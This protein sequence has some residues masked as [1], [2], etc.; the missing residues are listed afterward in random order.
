M[1]DD[2]SVLEQD[3]LA[4]AL[5]VADTVENGEERS[6][7]MEA[8]A[9]DYAQRRDLSRAVELVE[10]ISDPY[11]KD[12]ALGT[13]AACSIDAGLPDLASELLDAIDD[14]SLLTLAIEQIAIRYAERGDFNEAL[15]TVGELA[16][17]TEVISNIAVIYA[18]SGL[19]EEAL[20]LARSLEHA[21]TKA[22]TLGQLATESLNR[23]R[24]QEAEELLSEAADAIK[25]ID[26]PEDGVYSLVGIASVYAT[27]GERE[28][29]FA[30]LLEAA[31]LC[32]DI[33]STSGVGLTATYVRD[34]AL[35]HVVGGLAE[36]N[37][38]EKADQVL[39]HIEDPFQFSD[40]TRSLAQEHHKSG[41]PKEAEALLA[42]A[43]EVAK[44]PEVT[45]ERGLLLQSEVFARL[46]YAYA[47]CGHYQES[48]SVTQLINGTELQTGVL[49]EIGKAAVSAGLDPSQAA[50]L[51][52]DA[53][54]AM[55]YWLGICDAYLALQQAKHA[56][57]ALSRAEA[58]INASDIPY[59]QSLT[60]SEIALRLVR[61]DQPERADRLFCSALS[62]VGAIEGSYRRASALLSLARKYAEIDREPSEEERDLLRKMLVGL[63]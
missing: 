33:E 19:A 1:R 12:R 49:Q 54:K 30:T 6:E 43:V 46:A 41:R 24:N 52:P 57:D 25:E 50:E 39:E 48:L 8:I 14:P 18:K 37:F 20:N 10:S 38:F 58:A 21:M 42:Q 55:S 28:R 15:E 11:L 13:V 47:I 22:S 23:S 7:I 3:L 36:L 29:A 17:N 4:S 60:L 44:D 32:D 26:L 63:E 53:T 51:L 9:V 40:A 61:M 5:A 45:G 35:S 2:D 62:T 27:L 59:E 34:Q 16:D 56:D 31:N